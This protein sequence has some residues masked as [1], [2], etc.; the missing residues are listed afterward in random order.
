MRIN[1]HKYSDQ[2]WLELFYLMA[3]KG[4][5]L[6]HVSYEYDS[7]NRYC[8]L[9]SQFRFKHPKIEIN[10]IVKLSE[11]DF[12]G[13]H[14]NTKEMHRKIQLYKDMLQINKIHTIQWMWRGSLDIEKERLELLSKQKRNIKDYVLRLKKSGV[15][16]NFFVFP[17]TRG[18]A[19]S[20]LKLSFSDGLIVYRN[21]SETSYDD[22]IKECSNLN[23][24]CIVI[25][26]F[27]AGKEFLSDLSA[28][29]LISFSLNLKPIVGTIIS[30]SNSNQ[31][32]F[33]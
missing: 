29:E 15:I 2:H 32:N 22:L 5:N 7:F 3:S 28:D 27:N 1:E 19:K 13:R 24:K 18:F 30:F 10:H 4:I 11:P 9:L 14:F 23:K 20:C 16:K 17:Y 12:D 21:P 26:P 25:R 31:L 6:H 33:S 8:D